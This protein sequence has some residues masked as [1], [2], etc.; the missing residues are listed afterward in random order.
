MDATWVVVHL[1]IGHL[2]ITFLGHLL[3]AGWNTESP[4]N[5]QLLPESVCRLHEEQHS[6]SMITGSVQFVGGQTIASHT[7]F[8]R[9]Q[10]H[11]VQGVWVADQRLPG[12]RTPCT[13]CSC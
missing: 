9:W 4:P 6:P 13:M 3:P 8:P 11:M 10:L 5:L 2:L 7:T 12:S 1:L